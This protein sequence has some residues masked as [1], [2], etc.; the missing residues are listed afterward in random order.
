MRAFLPSFLPSNP[1][2]PSSIRPVSLQGSIIEKPRRC[3]QYPPPPPLPPASLYERRCTVELP[4]IIV[5]YHRVIHQADDGK[6]R[7]ML[8]D[9][10]STP[11]AHS[12]LLTH[13]SLFLL[14]V[15]LSLLHP[16]FRRNC[17]RISSSDRILESELCTAN[18]SKGGKEGGGGRE[19]RGNSGDP[20]GRGAKPPPSRNQNTKRRGPR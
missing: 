18:T 15:F 16:S 2:L 1:R 13:H 4:A 14:A 3:E 19:K 11:R 12:I 8:D 10:R 17:L 20:P 5:T 6:R 7:T 9:L